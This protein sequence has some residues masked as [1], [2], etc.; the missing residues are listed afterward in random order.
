MLS[1]L[2]SKA[3]EIHVQTEHIS[4]FI[5]QY[6]LWATQQEHMARADKSQSDTNETY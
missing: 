3:C 2:E 6:C 5:L 4:S 1:I